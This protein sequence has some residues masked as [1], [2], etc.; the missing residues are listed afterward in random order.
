M[1]GLYFALRSGDEHRNLRHNPCQ[2]QVVE[3]QGERPYLLYTEDI[4]KNRPGGLKGQ[5]HKPKVVQHHSNTENPARCFVRLFKLYMS[6]CPPDC[7][8]GAFYLGPL[9]NPTNDCWYSMVP[10][11]RNKLAKAVSKMCEACGIEGL[12]T[13]HSLRATAATRLYSSGID[14]QL[15]MERTGHRSLE[16]IR[17][18][19]HTSADQKE[20]VS[21]ILSNTTKKQCTENTL[22]PI[23]SNTTSV[24]QSRNA[25]LPGSYTFNQCGSVTI[26]IN[27]AK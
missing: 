4:S 5:K 16:G 26:N 8:D 14:E 2:I 20:I 18:Y 1:N 17:S 25:S 9:K 11:G 23:A 21:D 12:K 22:M 13:N 27:T 19:K 7:P 10:V 6:L 24:H 15:V 3:R